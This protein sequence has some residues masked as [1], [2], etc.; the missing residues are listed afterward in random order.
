SERVWI[1]DIYQ[2]IFCNA[3]QGVRQQATGR[4]AEWHDLYGRRPNLP[5]SKN[6]LD[7]LSVEPVRT[8]S[9]GELVRP[10]G[11][12]APTPPPMKISTIPQPDRSLSI[13]AGAEAFA[14]AA[15]AAVP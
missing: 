13:P 8:C 2:N 7:N 11:L 9:N 12:T 6:G 10:M 1:E 4:V 5:D 15:E 14:P 3:G